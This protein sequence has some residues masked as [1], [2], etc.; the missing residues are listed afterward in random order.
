MI[1]HEEGCVT[2]SRKS[3]SITSLRHDLPVRLAV[4]VD[5]V[6]NASFL[7]QRRKEAILA[8]PW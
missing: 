1:F 2:S 6:L 8:A 5:F 4:G 3:A 7:E